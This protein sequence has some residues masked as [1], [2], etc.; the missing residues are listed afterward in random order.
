[1]GLNALDLRWMWVDRPRRRLYADQAWT[2]PN[3]SRLQGCSWGIAARHTDKIACVLMSRNH[4]NFGH[5]RQDNA[6]EPIHPRFISCVC[7]SCYR[8]RSW[9]RP[10]TNIE[11]TLL[12]CLIL[13]SFDRKWSRAPCSCWG[14]LEGCACGRSNGSVSPLRDCRIGLIF[15][16]QAAIVCEL[17]T[18]ATVR[19]DYSAFTVSGWPKGPSI[20]RRVVDLFPYLYQAVPGDTYTLCRQCQAK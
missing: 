12:V 11:D 16:L 4:R 14:C 5:E 13:G 1:M 2:C 17:M 15:D 9:A 18:H 8:D 10:A 20:I 6:L 3:Q 7:W 19:G